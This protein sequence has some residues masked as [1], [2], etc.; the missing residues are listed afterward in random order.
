MWLMSAYNCIRL[1]VANF[2]YPALCFYTGLFYYI[3]NPWSYKRFGAFAYIKPQLASL[4]TNLTLET[5]NVRFKYAGKAYRISKKRRILVLTMHYP[6]Y[7]YVVWSNIKLY[8]RRK[9]KK[10]FKFKTL[11]SLNLAPTFFAN[12]FKLRVPDTYTR[13]G[14]LNNVFAYE[15]RKQKAASQR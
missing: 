11:T 7:K 2:E 3:L 10:V 14:I 9:K 5:R 4:L 6:T 15:S 1:R 8:H 12:M 13:R